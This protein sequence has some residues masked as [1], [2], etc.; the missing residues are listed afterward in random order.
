VGS[1]FSVTGDVESA[2]TDAAYYRTSLYR[3]EK[4]RIQGSYQAGTQ[5]T[6]SAAFSALSNR[7]PSAG[8]DYDYLGMQTSASVLWNPRGDKRFGFQGTYTRATVHS[9]IIFL[10]HKR[11]SRIGR[12]TATIPFDQSMFDLKYEA[13]STGSTVGGWQFL[14]FLW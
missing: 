1:R 7:N 6:L 10:I 13:R 11:F 5:L 9:N 8:I 3:Y 12:D 2:G 14:H 4:G